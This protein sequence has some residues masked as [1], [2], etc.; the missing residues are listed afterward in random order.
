MVM[1]SVLVSR[2]GFQ[3]WSAHAGVAGPPLFTAGFVAQEA[4]LRDD[5]SPIADPI[6]ALE[7][8]PTGWLQ[9]L[10]FLAFA[11][12]LLIFA[13]GL[14]R[15]IA[16][17]RFGWA[18]P[19]LLG[20]AAVGLVLAAVFP[21]RE[22]QAGNAYDPGNHVIA[23]VTFFSCSALALLVLSRRFAAD[24]RWRGLAR[25][26]G[27]AGVVGLGCFVMLGRFAM[28]E[29]APLH[30]VAGLLQRFTLLAVTF[31]ALLTIALRLRRLA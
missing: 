18:G 21:L 22:D 20:A 14:H 15:G 19:A 3:R 2:T 6:S 25:Y 23:G 7:A 5:Y 27:V 24:P 17:T 1:T 10:N 11:A 4:F 16:A 29:G 30:D 28:P 13:A 12:L 26:V 8:D 9:Q 31:P